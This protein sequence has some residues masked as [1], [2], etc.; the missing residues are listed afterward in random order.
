MQRLVIVFLFLFCATEVT[1]SNL[2]TAMMFVSSDATWKSSTKLVQGWEQAEF[3]DS[4]WE[5]TRSP[6]AGA[7]SLSKIKVRFT[8]PMWVYKGGEFLTA[9][10]RKTFTLNGHVKN[11]RISAV[12]D[13]D[14]DIYINGVKVLSDTSGRAEAN[15]IVLDV[16][17]H[18]REGSN[19]LAVKVKDTAGGCQWTQILLEIEVESGTV[20]DVPLLKQTDPQWAATTY[21]TSDKQTLWCGTDIGD[22]GCALTSVSMLL[23]Y[24]GIVNLAS[25]LT[26]LPD[27]L[28]TYFLQDQKC[29][30]NQCVS[31]GYVFGDVRWSV[32][33][34]LSRQAWVLFGT[35]KVQYMG[36]GSLDPREDIAA[37]KPVIGKALDKSHWFVAKGMV[38]DVLKINDPIFGEM[39]ATTTALIRRFEEVQSDFSLIEAYVKAPGQLVVTDSYGRQTGFVDGAKVTEIPS[40]T[41]EF[42][43][44]IESSGS[45]GLWAA[46]ITQPENGRY[47]IKLATDSAKSPIAAYVADMNADE[48]SVL[49]DEE[50]E[51]QI[52]YDHDRV[53]DTTL[54]VTGVQSCSLLKLPIRLK[55]TNSE[56]HDRIFEGEAD[57]H[58]I[59]TPSLSPKQENAPP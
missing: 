33:N 17:T 7:C 46:R 48:K 56:S 23:Q 12:F 34:Q 51:I 25:G 1:A 6:S 49:V 3:D 47:S 58:E 40:S 19:T 43:Q 5:N 59:F 54:S 55:L 21:D 9:Y 20:L 11:A 13:D 18:F 30:L 41:Y 28:N 42:E 44:S 4:S 2:S 27:D 8:T 32:V 15:P 45:A 29:L 24:Y 35:A 52:H 26:T 31:R 57:L 37:G 16:S 36:G 14:G 10:F 38:E 53:D 39:E 50:T 22:C